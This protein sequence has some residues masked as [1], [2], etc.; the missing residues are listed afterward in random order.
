MVKPAYPNE[1][2]IPLA[3]VPARFGLGATE[4]LGYELR[5]LGLRHVLLV[6][7]P[8]LVR[9]G[10]AGKVSAIIEQAGIR[11]T[12]YDDVLCEPTDESVARA[13]A[14]TREVDPEGLVALG[15]GS[16][17]DTAKAMNLCAA[18]PASVLA[19]IGQPI[20]E[21]R[22]VPGPLRPLVTVPTTA[23]S[24]SEVTPTLALGIT[25]LRLKT[26]MSHPHL[27]PTMAI[28]DPLNTLT[29]PPFVTAC[30][31]LDVL[32]Q[33]IESYTA[34]RYDRRPAP[35]SPSER[36]PQV[37]ANP[38][39]DVWSLQAITCCSQYLR[40]ACFNGH[41]LEAR[42]YMLMASIC[43]RSGFGNAG[44][45]IPHAMSYPV[46]SMVRDYIPPD[47]DAEH[48]MIPH[49]LAVA[50]T[51]PAVCRFTAPL[52]PARHA[53]V[54][55]LLDDSAGGLADRPAADLLPEVLK[56][57]LQDLGMPAGLEALGFGEA[58]IPELVEGACQQGRLLKLAPRPV[59]RQDLAALFRAAL[60]YW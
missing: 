44:V 28:V 15:G 54:A 50:L 41:D 47:Y 60:R 46:A 45:H 51:L 58:D 29:V 1:T 13:A 36:P 42:N 4:E 43:S 56:R 35:P 23:G 6:T 31:G 39:S 17:I 33:A 37:G 8:H 21:G 52:D 16:V 53:T 40:R 34:I 9:L 22:P 59:T 30:S 26:G 7:D 20:G 14:F 24:G 32:A 10:L 48:P 25:A 5:R 2:I 55:R 38:F 11:V 57:L 19:Y 18:H 3:A 27:S 12:P 49:G